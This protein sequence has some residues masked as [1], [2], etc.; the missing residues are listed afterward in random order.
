[1]PLDCGLLCLLTER[2][3][4]VEILWRNQ[5]L[6]TVDE[7][8]AKRR[9]LSLMKGFDTEDLEVLKKAIVSDGL[10]IMQCAPGPPMDLVEEEEAL[11]AGCST[12]IPTIGVNASRINRNT[13]VH[14]SNSS[15]HNSQAFNRANNNSVNSRSRMPYVAVQS[16]DQNAN[17]SATILTDAEGNEVTVDLNPVFN[18]SGLIPQI[19]RPMSLPYLCCKMWR[20]RTLQIDAALHKLEPLPWCR[21]GRVT[22]NNATVSCCNPY[23]Y[24]L[25]IRRNFIDLFL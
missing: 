14:Y 12:M 22:I 4:Y 5:L 23:H 16:H 20:W 8:K 6:T 13:S 11:L 18:D 19:D 2:R 17:P 25:W 15:R 10:E 21:F 1:M 7:K 3:R 9:F 24:G